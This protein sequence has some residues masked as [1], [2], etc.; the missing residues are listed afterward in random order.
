FYEE[1]GV[2][3]LKSDRLLAVAYWVSFSG[4]VVVRDAHPTQL[5]TSVPETQPRATLGWP[6]SG[7]RLF[8]HH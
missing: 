6:Y 3:N 5:W 1:N 8:F 7:L 4:M 2:L